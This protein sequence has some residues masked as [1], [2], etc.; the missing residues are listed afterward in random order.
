M[1]ANSNYGA[2]KYKACFLFGISVIIFQFYLAFN[3]NTIFT[4]NGSNNGKANFKASEFVNSSR[5]IRQ[6]EMENFPKPFKV[7]KNV[8]NM[9]RLKLDFPVSCTIDSKDSISAIHRA[10]TVRCKELIANVSCLAQEGILFPKILSSSCLSKRFVHGKSL[11]CY[12]DDKRYRLLSGYYIDNKN[13]NFPKLCIQQ[14][15]QSGFSYA[16]VEFS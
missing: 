11:G 13:N 3:L 4:N 8:Y 7:T 12:K 16:G 15:L 6:I 2:R 14:C 1:W 5:D 10:K 9:T